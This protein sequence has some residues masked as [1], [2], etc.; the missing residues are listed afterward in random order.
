MDLVRDIFFLPKGLRGTSCG[1]PKIATRLR[2]F[3]FTTDR[4]SFKSDTHLNA[5][6]LANCFR[7]SPETT[8]SRSDR[9][10]KKSTKC[11][12][13]QSLTSNVSGELHTRILTAVSYH[14][15]KK[16]NCRKSIHPRS[17]QQNTER[18]AMRL[19]QGIHDLRLIIGHRSRFRSAV[20]GD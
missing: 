16:G 7:M 15:R 3:W 10:E 2:V 11:L 9:Q 8:A 13:D 1:I 12:F 14:T 5:Y 20:L 17:L 18:L 4:R 19:R 6:T